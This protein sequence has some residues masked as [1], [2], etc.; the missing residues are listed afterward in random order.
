MFNFKD[1]YYLILGC[2]HFPY[3]NVDMF[4][5][6]LEVQSDVK[7]VKTILNGVPITTKL[8]N[9]IYS[10]RELFSMVMPRITLEAPSPFFKN[11]FIAEFG[12]FDEDDKIVKIVDGKLI[13]GIVCDAMIKI[14]KKNTIYHMI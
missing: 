9:R 10:G 14:G 8:E 11:K 6:F 5:L 7:P 1:G 4:D 12:D 13:S 2:E 3:H